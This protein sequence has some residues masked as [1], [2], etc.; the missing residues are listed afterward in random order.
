MNIL[1]RIA[2]IKDEDKIKECIKCSYEK[3]IERI[4]K[5]P[6]PM[7]DEYHSKIRDKFVHV[8]NKGNRI[9]GVIVLIPKKDHLYLGNL[10]VHPSE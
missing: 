9:I 1:I 6:A 7:L 8:V 2:D 4:G 3:Y 10:A 5:K